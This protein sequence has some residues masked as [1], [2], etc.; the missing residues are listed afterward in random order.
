MAS[1]SSTLLTAEQYLEIDREAE[2]NREYYQ[3]EMLPMPDAGRRHN[4][5][6]ANTLALRHPQLRGT[7]FEAYPTTSA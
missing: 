6:V 4:L 5:L 3:G 2:Y 7:E 1:L